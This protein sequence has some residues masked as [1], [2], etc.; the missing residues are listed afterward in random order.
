MLINKN[1]LNFNYQ[2]LNVIKQDNYLLK[3]NLKHRWK[4]ISIIMYQNLPNL[5]KFGVFFWD[6]QSNKL[7]FHNL[8]N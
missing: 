1:K 7:I 6:Y 8:I 2:S 4:F 3:I 5:F